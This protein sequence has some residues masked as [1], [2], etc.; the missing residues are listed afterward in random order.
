MKAGTE[1]RRSKISYER[2]LAIPSM[3]NHL[4]DRET[5]LNREELARNVFNLEAIRTE[6][7]QIRFRLD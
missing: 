5:A 4:A 3:Q 2:P 7:N 6:W 1:I